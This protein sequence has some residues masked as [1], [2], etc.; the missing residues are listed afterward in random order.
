[1]TKKSIK[2]TKPTDTKAKRLSLSKET[3]KDLGSR[4]EG[5]KG[6]GGSKSSNGVYC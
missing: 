4:G 5:P 3:L 6:G 2:S 1:M